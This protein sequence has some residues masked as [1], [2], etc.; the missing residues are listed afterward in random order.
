MRGRFT[1]W[2]F[3]ALIF[4]IGV[5]TGSALT[6]GFRSV[7]LHPP[8]AHQMQSWWLGRLDSRLHLTPEQKGRIEPILGQAGD[9]IRKLHQD[10]MEK[11]T[12]ILSAADAQITP[13]LTPGQQTEFEKMHHER[14]LHHR[15]RGVPGGPPNGGPP[16]PP[17]GSPAPSPDEPRHD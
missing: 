10:E 2:L 7:W 5:V 11:I 4:V 8:G 6:I 14:A 1:P 13:L 15:H 17:P 3:M 16:P 9:Q 12:Q